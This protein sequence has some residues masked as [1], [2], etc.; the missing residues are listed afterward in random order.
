MERKPPVQGANAVRVP[1]ALARALGAPP[2]PP[3]TGFSR[4]P[5]GL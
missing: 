5:R 2:S 1:P 4:K 3:V